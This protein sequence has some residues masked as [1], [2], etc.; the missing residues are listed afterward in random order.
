MHRLVFQCPI[1][2]A[3]RNKQD[4]KELPAKQQTEAAEGSIKE[5]EHRMKKEFSFGWKLS[6]LQERT[7]G[8]RCRFEI[9]FQIVHSYTEKNELLSL[10][11]ERY[12]RNT[13]NAE[14]TA[15]TLRGEMRKEK[16]NPVQ[17]RQSH[18]KIKSLPLTLLLEFPCKILFL[19]D[20]NMTCDIKR[21]CKVLML[22]QP[23]RNT[24]IAPSYI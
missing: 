22:S 19:P 11:N 7:K 15:I 2:K 8:K 14:H 9:L 24:R 23:G 3:S 5:N 1:K 18:A 21:S 20:L 13:E 12:H 17:Y 4:L 6:Q 10:A 16:K